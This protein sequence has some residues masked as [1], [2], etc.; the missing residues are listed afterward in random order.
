MG[1]IMSIFPP[2]FISRTTHYSI[3]EMYYGGC[4]LSLLR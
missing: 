1:M 2:C 3:I 4:T